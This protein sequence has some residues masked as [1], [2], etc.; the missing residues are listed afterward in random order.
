M[1]SVCWS[2]EDVPIDIG[3][4]LAPPTQNT[5]CVAAGLLLQ[6]RERQVRWADGALGSCIRMNRG[7]TFQRSPSLRKQ[8][9]DVVDA[10]VEFR[11]GIVEQAGSELPFALLQF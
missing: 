9:F 3:P 2:K 8:A 7:D 11:R 5:R 10:E 6:G 1:S 4:K